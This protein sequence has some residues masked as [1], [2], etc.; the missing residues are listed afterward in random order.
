M[1]PQLTPS[2][3]AKALARNKI[4]TTPQ[5]IEIEEPAEIEKLN[6]LCEELG[7]S[8]FAI[9]NDNEFEDQGSLR[10]TNI[11]HSK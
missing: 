7:V 2:F 11:S 5:L 9:D 3:I 10:V 6:Q 4:R 1:T 8:K